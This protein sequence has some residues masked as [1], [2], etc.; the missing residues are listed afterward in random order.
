MNSK[1]QR[2]IAII[3]MITMA[4]VIILGFTIGLVVF[5]KLDM[6]KWNWH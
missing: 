1:K 3:T 5:F 4:A 6:G 2:K